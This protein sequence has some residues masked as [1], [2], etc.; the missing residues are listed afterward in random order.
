MVWDPVYQYVNTTEYEG[1]GPRWGHSAVMADDYTLFVIFGCSSQ[2]YKNDINIL[3][4]RSWT[5]TYTYQG[6]HA[7]LGDNSTSKN[8][9]SSGGPSGGVIAGITIGVVAGLSIVIGIIVFLFLRRK[10]KQQRN[11]DGEIYTHTEVTHDTN[12]AGSIKLVFAAQNN[13]TRTKP[14]IAVGRIK[15]DI[16]EDSKRRLLQSVKPD[17]H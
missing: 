3:D 5:W 10:R 11:T 12:E 16:V 8:N 14:D 9:T 15:P 1:A 6:L 13:G 4:T 2:G 17:G 7:A